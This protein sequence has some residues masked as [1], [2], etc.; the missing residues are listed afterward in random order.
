MRPAPL[1][2]LLSAAGF[3]ALS[4]TACAPKVIRYYGVVVEHDVPADLTVT[5][6]PSHSRRADISFANKIETLLLQSKVKVVERPVFRYKGEERAKKARAGAL[7]HVALYKETAADYIVATYVGDRRI[8]ILNRASGQVVAETKL[9]GNPMLIVQGLLAAA[10]LIDEIP[11]SEAGYKVLQSM[12]DDVRPAVWAM[13]SPEQRAEIIAHAISI[14]PDKLNTRNAK[15]ETDSLYNMDAD[16]VQYP[17]LNGTDLKEADL[18]LI[19][20]LDKQE[21]FLDDP[22]KSDRQGRAKRIR[23]K[24]VEKEKAGGKSPAEPVKKKFS[25]KRFLKRLFDS[26]PP[27]ETRSD[28]PDDD[29]GI[30]E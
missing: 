15:V 23:R 8:R 11:P 7:D 6:I 21:S 14:S 10:G 12:D 9:M 24:L 29:P 3:L 4:L 2:V 13:L 20:W 17:V 19:V 30:V 28:D 1:T 22:D 27:N 25:G 16:M 26:S 18:E 5:V